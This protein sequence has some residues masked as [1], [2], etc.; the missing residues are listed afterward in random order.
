MTRAWRAALLVGVLGASVLTAVGGASAATTQT[1]EDGAT[2]SGTWT[3]VSTTDPAS[4]YTAPAPY[5][6]VND[7]FRLSTTTG[8]TAS[9]TFTGNSIT[10]TGAYSSDFGKADIRVDGGPASTVDLYIKPYETVI[11]GSTRNYKHLRAIFIRDGLADGT[12]TITVTVTGQKNTASSGYGVGIDSFVA[13][14][15]NRAKNVPVTAS[16]SVEGSGWGRARLVDGT[17]GST[18]TSRGWSS[19]NSLTT[20]HAEWVQADLGATNFLDRIDLFPRGD[21]GSVG[22]YF[23]VDFSIALSNDGTT[24][25]DVVTRTGYPLPTAAAQTFRFGAQTARYIRVTGTNLRPNPDESNWYRMQLA[26]LVAA[27]DGYQHSATTTAAANTAYYVSSSSGNDANTGTSASSPWRTLQKASQAIY[28]GGNSVLLKRGDSWSGQTLHLHGNGTAASPIVAGAYGSGAKPIIVANKGEAMASIKI[29]NNHGYRISGLELTGGVFGLEVLLDSTYGHDFLYLDDLYVHD[30]E[31]RSIGTD[32]VFPYPESYFG[33]GIL[34][35]SLMTAAIRDQTVYSNITLTNSVISQTDTGY[36]NLVRDRPLDYSG[37]PTNAWYSDR[38]VYRD[39]DISNTRIYRSYRSGGVMLYGTTGGTTDNVFIDE[40][41]Y[42]K[43]MFWGVAAFQIANSQ[44]YVVRNSE[45]ARTYK[46]NGSPDG[47]GF[48]FEAGN[49]GVTLEN[50]YIH[51]NAGPSMLL[52]GENGGWFLDNRDLVVDGVFAYRN[53]T[54]GAGFDS[55]AI[56]NYPR[57][58]GVIRNSLFLRKFADQDVTSSPVAFESTNYI[59]NSDGSQGFGPGRTRWGLGSSASASSTVNGYGWTL[60]NAVDGITS[61]RAGAADTTNGWSSNGT[62]TTNHTEWLQLDL[63]Q[64]RTIGEV[65]LWAS[66]EDSTSFPKDFTI[67]VSTNGTSWTTVAT[68][69]NYAQP[70]VTSPKQAF[71]FPAQAARYVKITGTNLRSNPNESGYYR[72]QFA[73]VDVLQLY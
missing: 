22:A 16:S 4:P 60:P 63:G 58:S 34:V 11:N 73:E 25:T 20:N 30:V 7:D 37:L 62:L 35:S 70:A 40:T 44:D 17:T 13:R 56:K 42:Q 26:E 55:K 47:E 8:S 27:Y 39:V 12:H 61:S 46:S 41:G 2:Y 68:R 65:D 52:Y 51:D 31:G 72:M 23:P 53:G 9:F 5:G 64:A 71:T 21:A 54:E 45:F 38:D 43:G 50:S 49:I 18:A 32:L 19:T 6:P 14:D 24:W 36:I 57:N 29:V 59:Q 33:A 28:A 10:V 1:D 69:T 48:D 66:D 15:T 67:Q 3:T